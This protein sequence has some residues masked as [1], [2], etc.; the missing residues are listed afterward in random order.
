MIK[1]KVYIY[2]KYFLKNIIQID[3]E[4]LNYI[5]LEQKITKVSDNL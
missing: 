4:K 3:I 1:Q 5:K 2:I